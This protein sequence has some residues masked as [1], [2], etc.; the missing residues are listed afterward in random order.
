MCPH[1]YKSTTVRLY[2]ADKQKL[3]ELCRLTH[4]G[5]GHMLSYLIDREYASARV[6]KTRKASNHAS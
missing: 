5:L 3:D 1:K 2:P 6:S 4:R